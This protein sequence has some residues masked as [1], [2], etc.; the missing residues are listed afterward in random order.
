VATA[1]VET[2]VDATAERVW[3]AVADVG[4]VHRRLLPGRSAILTS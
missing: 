1:R 2:T 3:D 4:A